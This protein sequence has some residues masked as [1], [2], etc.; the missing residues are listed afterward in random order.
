MPFD[1]VY[2]GDRNTATILKGKFALLSGLMANAAV[3]K[4]VTCL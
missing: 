3:V 2:Y 4:M 1:Y